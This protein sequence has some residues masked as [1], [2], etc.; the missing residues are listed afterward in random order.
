MFNCSR[1]YKTHFSDNKGKCDYHL[2]ET[3]RYIF[4]RKG[5]KHHDKKEFTH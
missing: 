2:I 5:S 3:F 1:S 4:N